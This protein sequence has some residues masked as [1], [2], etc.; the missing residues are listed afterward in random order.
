MARASGELL[1]LT[2]VDR[3]VIFY[4]RADERLFFNWLSSIRCVASVAAESGDGLVVRL[5]R[6]P[7]QDD[8]RQFAALLYRYRADMRQ[9]AKFE[10]AANRAWFKDPRKYWYRGVFGNSRRSSRR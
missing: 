8:L 10:T 1:K 7:G 2:Q 5:K 6:R 9:L 4:H 3:G